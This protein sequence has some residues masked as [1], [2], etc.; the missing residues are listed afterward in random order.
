MRLDYE[1]IR[2]N[3]FPKFIRLFLTKMKGNGSLFIENNGSE[4]WIVFNKLND[5]RKV[6]LNLAFPIASWSLQY[7][8]KFQDH[9]RSER[10]QFDTLDSTGEAKSIVKGYVIVPGL[11]NVRLAHKVA[12][13][14]I[15]I[16]EI[17]SDE[18]FTLRY[19]HNEQ[20]N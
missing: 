3:Q 8:P 7:V 1:N 5:Q 16:M 20:S 19:V 11:P 6:F 15:K 18:Y 4:K 12:Q 14:A 13:L 10:I 17:Q 2:A 9:L